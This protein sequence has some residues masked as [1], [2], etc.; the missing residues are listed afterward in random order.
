M[1]NV[2]I[3]QRITNKKKEIATSV[4]QIAPF[5]GFR[6]YCTRQIMPKKNT[7]FFLNQPKKTWIQKNKPSLLLIGRNGW[8][9]RGGDTVIEQRPSDHSKKK[10]NNK[11]ETHSDLWPLLHRRGTETRARGLNRTAD[12]DCLIVCCLAA[13]SL[14]WAPGRDGKLHFIVFG[15]QSDRKQNKTK[16]DYILNFFR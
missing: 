2:C 6:T 16:E 12:C 8:T 3:V 10:K 7:F 15:D 11:K 9:P 5:L 1:L 4:K 14:R 13:R